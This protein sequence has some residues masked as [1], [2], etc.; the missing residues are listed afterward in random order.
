MKIEIDFSRPDELRKT[1]RELEMALST[2]ES[3]LE[4]IAKDMGTITA[5]SD[6]APE[7]VTAAVRGDVSLAVLT[8][9]DMHVS[10]IIDNLTVQQFTFSQIKSIADTENIPDTASEETAK[11]FKFVKIRKPILPADCAVYLLT[12][13]AGHPA[14]LMANNPARA[15]F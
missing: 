7:L 15:C 3:A 2:I 4:A 14:C 8:E 12:A 10:D 9:S 1:K 13:V 6:P 5:S 11:S